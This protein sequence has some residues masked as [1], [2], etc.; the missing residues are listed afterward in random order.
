MSSSNDNED[1]CPS[2]SSSSAG[3]LQ[4]S[5]PMLMP[6]HQFAS[7]SDKRIIMSPPSFTDPYPSTSAAGAQVDA[8]GSQ[9]R[10]TAISIQTD[11]VT[12][13]KSELSPSPD[14]L[15]ARGLDSLS[16]SEPNSFVTFVGSLASTFPIR[17]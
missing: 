1:E 11:S 13:N 6:M 12:Y 4:R 16:L 8:K 10:S 7:R 9:R 2:T 5:S 15:A 3:F 14:L 17:T